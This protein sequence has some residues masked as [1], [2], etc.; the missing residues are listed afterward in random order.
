MSG[1]I[2]IVGASLTGGTAAATLR[3]QGFDGPIVL[4]G[5]EPHPP[6][7]RPPLSKEYLRGEKPFEKALVKPPEFWESNGVQTRFGTTAERI[8]T[9]A[10]EVV[11]SGGDRIAYDK[12]L[13][14]TGVRNRR[15]SVP[16]VDLDGVHSLRTREEADAIRADAAKASRAVIVG[17]GFI[18]AEVA[19]SLRTIGLDVTAVEPTPTPLHRVLGSEVGGAIA[20][21]HADHGVH[22][23]FEDIVESLEGSSRVEGVVTKA[24]KRL[25]AD[26]VVV[27]VGVEPVTD[28]VNGTDIALENGI[29]VDERCRTNVDGV[30]AAGDIANHYHPLFDRRMRVE[31]WQNAIRQGQHVAKS[32]LGSEEPYL[33]IHWFWSDQYDA[34][35]QYAGHHREWD[36]LVFRGSVKERSFVAFYIKDG[37][38]E[39]AAALNRGRELRRAMG[40]IRARKPVDEAVLRDENVDL[41]TL[42]D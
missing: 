5:S 39:A 10:R 6:Y 25:P 21:L 23:I 30:Y 9:A 2:V 34:N 37:L 31:H 32:M 35:I 4:I 16:G 36:A 1:P 17:M 28:A 29:T 20:A 41:K 24:G 12:L 40:I 19:A 26:L 13:I 42:G 15:L 22:M 38:V 14:A 18:G 27:G 3:E 33:E 7:E 11:L 8:D